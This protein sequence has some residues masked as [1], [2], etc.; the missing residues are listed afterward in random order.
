MSHK[1]KPCPIDGRFHEGGCCQ[2][3]GEIHHCDCALEE[4]EREQPGANGIE[5]D[6]PQDLIVEPEE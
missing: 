5:P 3:C 6:S 1:L 4:W 2:K